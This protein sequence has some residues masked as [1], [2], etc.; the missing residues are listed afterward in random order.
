MK[1]LFSSVVRLKC[2]FIV[3]VLKVS[4]TNSWHRI[5][6]CPLHLHLVFQ[7]VLV[8]NFPIS[9]KAFLSILFFS[10]LVLRDVPQVILSFL[11]SF[12]LVLL[13]VL[14]IDVPWVWFDE[15]LSL[16]ISKLWLTFLNAKELLVPSIVIIRDWVANILFYLE[17]WIIILFVNMVKVTLISLIH[18][19]ILLHELIVPALFIFDF[20]L[21]VLV[22]ETV[23]LLSI[24]GSNSCLMLF[25]SIS[26]SQLVFS[27]H[28]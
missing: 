26:E 10:V 28:L 21:A 16:N 2:W 13:Q 24:H 11:S 27:I 3:F 12:H 23:P 17:L 4:T 9:L 18:C 22:E 15:S 7:E 14:E 6:A 8:A 19:L 1:N 25:L 20:C 5:Q